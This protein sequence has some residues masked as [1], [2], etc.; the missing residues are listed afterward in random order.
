MPLQNC[1]RRNR[2][3]AQNR[4]VHSRRT[5]YVL[6]LS[7]SPRSGGHEM[8]PKVPSMER[9]E[10]LGTMT[11]TVPVWMLLLSAFSPK[12]LLAQTENPNEP[13]AGYDPTQH[14]Y[15]MCVDIHKCIG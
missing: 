2:R 3:G 15:A 5:I 11:R 1:S 13:P 8:T 12:N 14:N 9:R 7:L 4:H 6:G 10:F